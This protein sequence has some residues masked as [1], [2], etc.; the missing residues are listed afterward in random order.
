[1]NMTANRILDLVR[2]APTAFTFSR[3]FWEGARDRKFLLQYC[4][5]TG[6]PQFY[7]RPISLQTGHR[8][9]EWREIPADGTVYTYTIAYRGA[10]GFR[11][12][13]PYLIATVELDAGVRI[14]GNV[15]N[16]EI[17]QIAIGMRVKPY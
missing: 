7:P 3:P 2:A 13:E 11:N 6:K 4:R 1:M 14:I 9:V 15:I 16:C 10:E 17:D 5:K 12:C 8:D